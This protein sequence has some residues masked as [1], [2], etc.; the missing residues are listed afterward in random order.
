MMTQT[1]LQCQIHLA[2]N[3]QHRVV[4]LLITC[5]MVGAERWQREATKNGK[6]DNAKRQE[7]D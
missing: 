3:I 7:L 6:V 4:L 2:L 5:L 1:I